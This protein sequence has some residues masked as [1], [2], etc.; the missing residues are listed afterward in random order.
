MTTRP[1]D[2]DAS[3]RTIIVRGVA[4]KEGLQIFFGAY[5]TRVNVW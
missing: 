5:E 3:E 2:S 4:E 1:A